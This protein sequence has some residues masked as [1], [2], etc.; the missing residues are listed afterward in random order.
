[1]LCANVYAYGA[2]IRLC[3]RVHLSNG[4]ACLFYRAHVVVIVFVN[5]RNRFVCVE[6]AYDY[7]CTCAY[8]C[9]VAVRAWFI[10]RMSHG[11]LYL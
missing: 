6:Y 11:L 8:A 5:A 2:Y 10:V 7:V 9:A 3:V 4:C 1:M